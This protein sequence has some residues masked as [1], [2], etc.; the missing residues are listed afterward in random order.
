MVNIRKRDLVVLFLVFCVFTL[1]F[2]FAQWS[3]KPVFHDAESIKVTLGGEDYSLQEAIDDGLFGGISCNWENWKGAFTMTIHEGSKY[4]SSYQTT[5]FKC[6]S[7]RITEILYVPC[8]VA[9]NATYK[10]GI[11]CSE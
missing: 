7:G 9:N 11:D 1:S 6:V 10:A 5:I 3:S 8:T 4:P 2:A